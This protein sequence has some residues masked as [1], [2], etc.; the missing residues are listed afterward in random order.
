M[1][2]DFFLFIIFQQNFFFEPFEPFELQSFN[3]YNNE[4]VHSECNSYYWSWPVRSR[5]WWWLSSARSY[6]TV[7]IHMYYICGERWSP[8]TW[9]SSG[10][11]IRVG[12]LLMTEKISIERH[13]ARWGRLW[14]YIG[15][16]HVCWSNSRTRVYILNSRWDCESRMMRFWGRMKI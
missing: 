11:S 15:Y 10:G 6:I 2:L 13:K 8:Y 14:M 16:T 12:W 7:C 5:Y 1:K 4:R 3:M 9:L